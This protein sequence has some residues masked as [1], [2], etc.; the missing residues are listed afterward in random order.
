MNPYPP[1]HFLCILLGL[2]MILSHAPD[3][4]AQDFEL[5]LSTTKIKPDFGFMERPLE[6]EFLELRAEL[7]HTLPAGGLDELT[8][9]Y[10]CC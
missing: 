10:Y 9:T 8:F 4:L 1:E 6:D 3:A 2:V 5:K 7:N